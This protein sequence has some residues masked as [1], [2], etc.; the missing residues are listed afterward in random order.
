MSKT[1]GKGK[2]QIVRRAQGVQAVRQALAAHG[3][4]LLPM[5]ELI[6]HA[7]ATV[8]ELISDAARVLIEQ[9]LQLSAYFS[10]RGRLFQSDRGRRFSV[11]VD[12]VS[13]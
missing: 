3:Q 6:E 12:G 11:I 4:A 5:L 8:D 1:T 7:Q 9:L 10:D 2:L 13:C